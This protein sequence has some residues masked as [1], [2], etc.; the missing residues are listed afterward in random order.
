MYQ[1]DN[2]LYADEDKLLDFKNPKYALD[3]NN[4]PTQVHLYSPKLRLGRMDSADN[5]VEVSKDEVK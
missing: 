1:I 3:E 4:T 5:Y 2:Y